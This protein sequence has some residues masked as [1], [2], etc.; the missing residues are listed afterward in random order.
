MLLHGMKLQ[1]PFSEKAVIF[2]YVNYSNQ[3]LK[4]KLLIMLLISDNRSSYLLKKMGTDLVIGKIDQ[5]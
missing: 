1:K 3:K 5:F 2:L 4:L